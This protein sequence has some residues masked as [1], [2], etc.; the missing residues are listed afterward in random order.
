LWPIQTSKRSPVGRPALKAQQRQ[1]HRKQE[2]HY[3]AHPALLHVGSSRDLLPSA[4]DEVRDQQWLSQLTNGLRTPTSPSR[5]VTGSVGHQLL[6]SYPSPEPLFDPGP[7]AAAPAAGQAAKVA[8]PGSPG[9]SPATSAAPPTTIIQGPSGQPGRPLIE[10]PEA[11]PAGQPAPAAG[12]GLLHSSFKAPEPPPAAHKRTWEGPSRI[13]STTVHRTGRCCPGGGSSNKRPCQESTLTAFAAN[14][15]EPREVDRRNAPA[16][17]TDLA[18]L[19]R[20]NNT[21]GPYSGGSS[22]AHSH[23]IQHSRSSTASTALEPQLEPGQ[24]HFQGS[25]STTQQHQAGRPSVHHHQQLLLLLQGGS[26]SQ[27]QQQIRWQDRAM[28]PT[29]R[30]AD[31]MQVLYPAAA[32]AL[33]IMAAAPVAAAV[34]SRPQL[35]PQPVS[36]SSRP[37]APRGQSRPSCPPGTQ[38]ASIRAEAA[39]SSSGR[40][41]MP[42]A[43]FGID[44]SS[45]TLARSSLRPAPPPPTG[46]AVWWLGTG[47][48]STVW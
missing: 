36:G 22:R 2:G 24:A 17:A 6:S 35:E 26:N 25:Y 5:I 37:L 11:P 28:A 42:Q 7:V 34:V 48:P 21:P 38:C 20:N 46:M 18:V 10:Q 1:P 44:S 45:L 13:S 4:K 29:G 33:P 41:L 16:A 23:T 47:G 31:I 8:V 43:G 14:R 19:L 9:G 30:Q 27:Q 40:P 32:A 12:A 15:T 39:S 3:Y